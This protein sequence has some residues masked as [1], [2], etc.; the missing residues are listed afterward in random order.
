MFM[1]EM[2]WLTSP[3]AIMLANTGWHRLR[4]T[5]S[6]HPSL[7]VVGHHLTDALALNV[8]YIHQDARHLYVQITPNWLNTTTGQRNLTNSYGNITLYD[9]VGRA[10]FDA[11]I[12]SLTYDRPGLRLNTAFTV[13]SYQSQFEGL[14]GYIDRSFLVMQPTS[15][16]ERWRLVLSGIGDLPFGL[17]LSTVSIFAA[18]RPYVAT[19]GRDLNSDNNFAD[20]FAPDSA[21]RVIRPVAAWNNMYRTVDLRLAKSCLWAAPGGSA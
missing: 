7:D 1:C 5:Y 11:L 2:P 19:D 21:H 10:K 13:G 3:A 17:T 6:Q 16:D 9:D 14:G 20:D 12:T 8:D 15:T 18:P 4:F